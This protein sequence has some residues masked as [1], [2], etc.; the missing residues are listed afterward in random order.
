LIP[1]VHSGYKR[2][3]GDNY[4]TIDPRCIYGLI[5]HFPNLG[6]VID[7]CANKGSAIVD[8]L[9]ELGYDAFCWPDA[10]R[11]WDFATDS[12]VTNP[13]YKRGL[14]D[15][16]IARQIGRIEDEKVKL[17]AI[18]LRANF[19]FAKS[20][21]LMFAEK[22]YLGQ[23]KLRFRP[24]WSKERKAQPIHNYCWHIWTDCYNKDPVILYSNGNPPVK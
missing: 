12:I 16:I 20:R 21:E 5:K 4:Q 23:I 10:L 11:D 19:D 1:Y 9:R 2:I 14:V 22:S 8:T 7:P 15:K 24:W 18:L 3:E 17:V 6:T 13:P